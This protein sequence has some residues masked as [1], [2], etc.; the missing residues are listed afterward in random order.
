MFW[1]WIGFAPVRS[2]FVLVEPSVSRSE[3]LVRGSVQVDV[4]VSYQSNYGEQMLCQIIKG[5]NSR[6]CATFLAAWDEAVF[7]RVHAS[8]TRIIRGRRVE[9]AS[10]LCWSQSV[11]VITDFVL[12]NK[13]SSFCT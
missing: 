2:W 13:P 6:R 5:K 3:R 9:L 11:M 4:R 8:L 1:S 10:D 7:S 12:T